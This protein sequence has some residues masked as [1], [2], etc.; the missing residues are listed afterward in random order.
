M[1]SASDGARPREGDWFAVPLDVGGFGVGLVA[2]VPRRGDTLLGYFFGPIRVQLPTADE[3]DAYTS[4]NAARICRF[5]DEALRSGRWP[6][7]ERADDWRREDWP[8]PEFYDAELEE[9]FGHGFGMTY[10]EEDLDQLLG[11]REVPVAEG[12]GMPPNLGA[13]S[14]E[15]VEYQL[16][17]WLGAAL[18]EPPRFSELREEGVRHFIVVPAARAS[19]ARDELMRLSFDQVRVIEDG[20][21]SWVVAFERGKLASLRAKFPRVEAELTNIAKRFDGE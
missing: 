14:Q 2:R 10:S 19:E 21:R 12:A 13:L 16:S 17:G 18:P 20:D 6:L 1:P 11:Q 4:R 3:I 15:A 5:L 8:L 9:V 7:I